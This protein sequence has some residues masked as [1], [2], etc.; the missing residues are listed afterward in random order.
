[1]HIHIV[2][3][4]THRSIHIPSSVCIL[5]GHSH[6]HTILYAHRPLI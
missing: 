3:R 5:I 1:M 2:A 4:P 6:S